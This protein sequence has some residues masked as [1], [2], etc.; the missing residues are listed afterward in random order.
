MANFFKYFPIEYY[1]NEDE[2]TL[3]AVTNITSRVDIL[4]EIKNNPNAYNVYS[5]NNGDTPEILADRF[6]DDVTKHWV[7]L[8]MNDIIDPHFDWALNDRSFIKYMNLKY[9]QQSGSK[10]GGIRW[11][12]TEPYAYFKL[13]KKENVSVGSFS[14]ETVP[15]GLEE[16]NTLVPS[17]DVYT[18][19]DGNIVRII[20]SKFIE[21]VYEHE[22]TIN[23]NKKIIKVLRPEF[24]PLITRQL[25]DLF[26]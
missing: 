20:V 24:L 9:E 11:S 5:V 18:L 26:E 7:I 1:P 12:Q 15:V 10:T 22:T 19:S 23:D 17:V 16:F 21:T 4:R 14:E 2:S 25:Q 8:M 13:I 6:Y 3:D